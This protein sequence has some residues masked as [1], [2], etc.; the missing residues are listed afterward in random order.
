ML[1]KS[2]LQSRLTGV[3]FCSLAV[4]YCWQTAFSAEPAAKK[5]S[6]N[7]PHVVFVVG[8][9]HYSADKTIPNF[10]KSLKKYGFRVTVI[11]PEG[12]P[13]HNKNKKG[14]LGLEALNSADLAVFYMR[15]LTLSDEQLKPILDYVQAGKPVIGIRTS[16]HAFDYPK[17]DPRSKWNDGFGRDVL[18]TKYFAHMD[19]GSTIEQIPSQRANTLLNAVSLRFYDPGHLYKVELPKDA[20]PLL[21]GT[22]RRKKAA[23]YTNRFGTHILKRE[24]SWP[25]AWTWK[26]KFGGKVF[27]TTLGHEKSFELYPLNRLLIN[28]IHAAL[29]KDVDVSEDLRAFSTKIRLHDQRLHLKKTETELGGHDPEIERKSFQLL[30]GFEV[31]LFAQEP[32]LVN[33]VHM[34]WDPQGRLWVCCAPS[35]PHVKPGEE[36]NDMIIVLEDTDQDGRADKS[37]VFADGLYVPTGLELGD[38]GVY[39]ANAPD[40]LFFKD[41]DGDLKADVKEIVLSGFATEDN[42]HAIS[43]WRWG[44]GG[45]LYFQ[46][47]IF[48][49]SQVETPHGTVRLENGGIFQFRPRDLKLRV[50]VDYHASNPWGHMFD[51]WGNEVLVDNSR[52]SFLSQLTANSRA[53]LNYKFHIGVTKQCGGEFSSGRHLPEEYRGQ[54]FTNQ[55]KAHQ[56]ARYKMIDDG[57]GQS[58]QELEPLLRSGYARFRPVDLKMGPDGAVYILDWYNTL[59]DHTQHMRDERRDTT[60]GRVWRVTYKGRPLVKRPQF[61][62]ATLAQVVEHLKDPEGWSRHQAK[63]VLYDSNPKQAAAALK[64]FVNSL[65]EDDPEYAHHMLEALWSFQTIDIVNEPLLRQVLSLKSRDA[66]AAAVR[67]LRYWHEQIDQPLGLLSK[68]IA[69][70]DPRVRLEAVLTLGFIP[71]PQSAVIAMRAT[72]KTMDTYL[73]H[74]L[75]LTID[76]LQQHWLEPY[77]TGKLKFDNSEHQDHALSLLVSNASIQVIIDMF[78]SGRINNKRLVGPLKTVA[79]KATA[80]QIEKLVLAMISYLWQYSGRVNQVDDTGAITM[81]LEAMEVA[82]SRRD[83]KPESIDLMIARCFA[84][85][86]DN[87]NRATANL[88][89]AWGMQRYA[90]RLKQI[91]KD[92][93]GSLLTQ[94]AAAKG[95]GELGTK[96]DLD[97]LKKMTASSQPFE[98]RALGLLGLT[99]HD[100]QATAAQVAQLFTNDPAGSDPSFLVNA[101]IR[102]KDGADILAAALAN[103]KPHPEVA[104]RIMEHF[105]RIGEQHEGLVKSLGREIKPGSLEALLQ[106][107]D[108]RQLAADVVNHGNPESGENIFRRKELACV[109]CHSVTKTG[110]NLGPGLGTIGSS[111][112][113]DYLVDSILRPSKEIKEFFDTVIVLTEDGI[114]ITGI[115][116]TKNKDGLIVRDPHKAGKEITILNDDIVEIK[117][118]ESLMPKGLANKLKNR[119]E[120]LDLTNF[121][122]QLGRPGPYATNTKPILRRWE[123]RHANSEA[124]AADILKSVD[125]SLPDSIAYSKVSGLLPAIDFQGNQSIAVASTQVD[126]GTAG[127]IKLKLNSTA[128]LSLFVG[129]QPIELKNDLV[130]DLKPG[131]QTLTFLINNKQRG[132]TGL[133]AEF[134]E[135]PGEKTTIQIVLRK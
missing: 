64:Q 87:V 38:G 107:E 83:I 9:T 132:N 128:G 14:L 86:A 12:D 82:A 76:G 5:K 58:I 35:Y 32:M 101:Y 78:N 31:N 130:L 63:R 33:P 45:W 77:N 69:D 20:V 48:M 6:E 115:L 62:G 106:K 57:S 94:Q 50:Y 27:A 119:Q 98:R 122:H 23:T 7:A 108:V 129:D 41:T 134:T 90:S 40:L 81:V 118:G 61:E 109:E 102:Q 19:A 135:I 13:E 43:A 127:K 49:H 11:V 59:I 103:S 26:N 47:G 2:H 131:R 52:V 28:A 30:D 55:Y 51:R 96:K 44:P 46:E 1:T 71:E 67:V 79:N 8:T 65:S 22:G 93:N 84:V 88:V 53:K 121:I 10:A 4:L 34:T 100:M 123:I 126:V 111:A 42:H 124:S 18:G 16:T 24:M 15:F 72:N 66:R 91:L 120:F 21:M 54:V 85:K 104:S 60:H 75:K 117:K 36:P 73:D 3:I 74:A 105:V 116:V 95:L 112:Q 97:F 92:K 68:L 113:P 99:S 25:V 39:V 89:G 114:I 56:I 37:T 110:A 17:E 133:F 70:E 80:P 29:G 125:N